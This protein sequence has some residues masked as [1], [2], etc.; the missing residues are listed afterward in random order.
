MPEAR[1]D[2]WRMLSEC[3]LVLVDDGYAATGRDLVETVLKNP[4]IFSSQKAFDVLGSP[5]PLVPIAFDPPE[6]TRY[7]RILQP[8]FSP[9]VIKPLEPDLRQQVIDLIEPIAA[10][11]E[12]DFIAE[13]AGVYPVQVFLTLFGLPLD[14][15]DQFV[16]WKNAVLGLTAAGGATAVDEAAQEGMQKAAEL[17]MYLSELIQKRRGVPGDDVLSQ[18]LNI[19]PPDAL[20]DEEAIGLCFL[21]VLAGLDTV[22]DALGFGMQRLAQ[23]PEKRRE[24]VEDL[25]LV[26]AATEELLRLDPPAPFLPR[27]TTEETTLGGQTL[28]EGTRISGYLATA[29][30][31]EKLFN[32][33]WNIDFHRPENRHISFG[34]GVHRC[35]GSHLA[36]LEMNLVYEEWHKRI[37]DY[38]ITPGTTPRVHWP[39]GTTGLD[40]LHL[41]VGK[42]GA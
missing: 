24:L 6:Q 33:A 16:E 41:T 9:R 3:P 29:N 13:V 2:A 31:D 23:N 19:E 30:R 18:V 34:M 7:R 38:H 27:V 40:S 5:V 10:K 25:S 4:S 42:A 8:F 26:P 12:C 36:R 39:R 1:D 17:F 11:G 15:R 14:M 22:M 37:P 32:D 35:L 20:S 28:P 21:F